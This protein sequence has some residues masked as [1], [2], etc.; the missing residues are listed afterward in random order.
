MWGVQLPVSTVW[1]SSC[2]GFLWCEP[3]WAAV[4]SPRRR[5]L[6]M[7][8]ALVF[9]KKDKSKTKTHTKKYPNKTKI[10]T[11]REKNK[12][13]NTES[14]IPAAL[15][16]KRRELFLWSTRVVERDVQP[17]STAPCPRELAASPC[18]LLFRSR[19]ASCIAPSQESF[20]SD[21]EGFH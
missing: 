18:C 5:D 9:V 14:R 12:E 8:L 19:Q 2:S 13:E 20:P 16:E 11:I 17:R 10:N 7:M 1:H 4:P 21:I 3:S 15:F 6:C